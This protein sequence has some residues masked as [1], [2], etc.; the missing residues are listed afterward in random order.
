MEELEAVMEGHRQRGIPVIRKSNIHAEVQVISCPHAV[1]LCARE[2]ANQVIR[3]MTKHC[4]NEISALL[5]GRQLRNQSA[6]TISPSLALEI[7]DAMMGAGHMAE[8]EVRYGIEYE[9]AFETR[10]R[11]VA[12]HTKVLHS[13]LD[14]EL[15]AELVV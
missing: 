2:L 13:H 14:L 1:E 12:S 10:S 5:G 9:W 15:L 8:F 3:T 4:L 7:I 11:L 6:S